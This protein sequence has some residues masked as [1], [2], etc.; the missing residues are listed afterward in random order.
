[1]SEVGRTR[2]ESFFCVQDVQI[3]KYV[4]KIRLYRCIFRNK[5][6]DILDELSYIYLFLLMFFNKRM[7]RFIIFHSAA[8]LFSR[9]DCFLC[10]RL[11]T[12]HFVIEDR[13]GCAFLPIASFIQK[14]TKIYIKRRDD[15]SFD[16][17]MSFLNIP[18]KNLE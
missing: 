2:I 9:L 13:I 15:I 16:I 6:L 12:S 8:L 18:K 17:Y 1:M 4:N 7:A 5:F 10:T 14:N 11:H 3:T